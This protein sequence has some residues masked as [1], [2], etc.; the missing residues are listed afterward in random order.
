MSWGISPNAS[1][2][3]KLKA[4]FADTINGYNSCGE[5]SYSVYSELFDIGMGLLDAI[6]EQGKR[7][8]IDK[9][10]EQLKELA[11]EFEAFGI[12]S[13]YVELSHAIDIVKGR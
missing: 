4:E 7:D 1:E 5:I 3:E 6:Y 10:V 13:D 8:A 12:C 2:K 9:V 11:I